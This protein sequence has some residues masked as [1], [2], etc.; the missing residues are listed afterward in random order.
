[1]G[2]RWRRA[3]IALGS[4]AMLAAGAVVVFADTFNG[5]VGTQPEE[6]GYPAD[7]LMIEILPTGFN[8]SF[9]AIPRHEQVLFFNNTKQTQRV[10]SHQNPYL[11]TGPIEPG[12]VDPG[13]SFNFAGQQH[14]Y[15]ESD[16]EI[17]GIVQTDSPRN[18]Q[19]LPPTPTPTPTPTP[20][21]TPTLTPTVQPTP[22]GRQ[23]VFGPVSKEVE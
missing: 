8:P 2:K 17:T 9:C 12:E 10:R 21:P 11:D 14:F 7:T 4:V 18:C 6:L 23:G 13:F 22:E 16:P 3:A 15:L 5:K 19:P 20:S 1:M